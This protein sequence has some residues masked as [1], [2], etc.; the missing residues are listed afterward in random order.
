M[1][2]GL[3]VVVRR[4][5]PR[6][7]RVRLAVMYAVL[8]LLAGT[9]LLGLTY[10]L[11][12]HVLLPAPTTPTK[13]ITLREE[14]LLGICKQAQPPGK[15][16]MSASLRERCDRG[17]TSTRPSRRYAGPRRSDPRSSGRLELRFRA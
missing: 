17:A 10:T 9:A 3:S 12:A 1:S 2:A 15:P 16:P 11:A 6:R 13:A 8:F 7:M 14:W 5:W 4:L